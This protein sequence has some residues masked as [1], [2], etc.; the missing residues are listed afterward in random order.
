MCFQ[1]D[2]KRIDLLSWSVSLFLRG[3]DSTLL[4]LEGLIINFQEQ[5]AMVVV[6]I[7]FQ[8]DSFLIGQWVWCFYWSALYLLHG[9][10]IIVSPCSGND[11]GERAAIERAVYSPINYTNGVSSVQYTLG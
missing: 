4:S 1:I 2:R 11:I 9:V 5:V 6:T 10:Q 3:R 7:T 8:D